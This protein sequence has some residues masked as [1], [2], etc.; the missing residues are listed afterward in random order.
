MCGTTHRRSNWLSRGGW[1]EE[2]K[3]SESR[4]SQSM[5]DRHRPTRIR[6]QILHMEHMPL[7][8]NIQNIKLKVP[9]LRQRHYGILPREQTLWSR[10]PVPA[11]ERR[12]RKNMC[13]NMRPIPSLSFG[14]VL[15]STCVGVDTSST[16]S[17]PRRKLPA[18]PQARTFPFSERKNRIN[19]RSL[20]HS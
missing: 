10:D 12:G 20:E 8:R 9:D 11:T 1:S 5:G 16:E 19:R 14:D 7:T 3:R 17:K 13:Q 2:E 15:L 6:P 18:R 4:S